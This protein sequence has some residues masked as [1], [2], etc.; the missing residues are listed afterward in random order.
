MSE[1][2]RATKGQFKKLAEHKKRGRPEVGK[3]LKQYLSIIDDL[4]GKLLSPDKYPDISETDQGTLASIWLL[5]GFDDF[6][7]SKLWQ[8]AEAPDWREHISE[9]Q[10]QDLKERIINS[11]Q[12]WVDWI[13]FSVYANRYPE[14]VESLHPA[15]QKIL[16]KIVPEY[17]SPEQFRVFQDLESA[18]DPQVHS[19]YNLTDFAEFREIE[20]GQYQ[21]LAKERRNHYLHLAD[22]IQE[23]APITKEPIWPKGWMQEHKGINQNLEKKKL[24]IPILQYLTDHA[25]NRTDNTI[26]SFGLYRHENGKEYQYL[27][28]KVNTERIADDVGASKDTVKKIIGAMKR[29][30]FVLRLANT[31]YAIGYWGSHR[32]RLFFIK[33]T[34]EIRDKLASFSYR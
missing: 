30:G 29:D 16:P 14:L 2:K 21:R 6:E 32:N 11:Y 9:D 17:Q 18:F 31:Y 3:E 4:H 27:V 13:Q 23:H 25:F 33:N 24:F 8:I 22:L 5:N 19:K 7:K 1:R 34:K 26:K 28:V 10:L 12:S 20:P 15:T